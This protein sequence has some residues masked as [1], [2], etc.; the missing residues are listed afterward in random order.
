MIRVKHR[1]VLAD[2]HKLFLEGIAA[3]LSSEKDIEIVGR[4]QTGT[5]ALKL[6]RATKP[7]LAVLDITMPEM[8]GIE[9]TQKVKEEMPETK[10]L[11]LSMHLDLR[12]IIEVLKVGADG[13]TLK[14][15]EPDELI[16]AVNNVLAGQMYLSPKVIKLI[17]RDYIQKQS[18]PVSAEQIKDLSARER[19]V[20]SLISESKSM[21]EI[22]EELCISRSTADTHRANLMKKLGCENLNELMRFAIRE[23]FINLDD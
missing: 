1:I 23:G 16:I 15:A 14:D 2:D 10:V 12:M 8:Y 6:I 5:E 19:Q 13:Y 18:V 21:K 4:A 7:E 17:V 22:A 11:I 9:V 3:L 20:L